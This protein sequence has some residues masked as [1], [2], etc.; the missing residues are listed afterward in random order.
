MSFNYFIF[1]FH[2]FVQSNPEQM[3]DNLKKQGGYIPGINL[4]REQKDI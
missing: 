4:V 3:A 2:T 1:L